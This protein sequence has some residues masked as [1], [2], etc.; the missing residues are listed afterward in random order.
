MAAHSS[1]LAW[2]IPQTEDPGRLQSVE[3][4]R[5]GHDRELSMHACT[6]IPLTRL[7]P[8]KNFGVFLTCSLILSIS[9]FPSSMGSV[10][11]YII[12]NRIP[13]PGTTIFFLNS[14][15]WGSH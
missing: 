9:T 6:H 4:Q 12:I 11:V 14:L 2:R 10:Y 8:F 5:V 13:F 1:I 7:I 3:S 15:A